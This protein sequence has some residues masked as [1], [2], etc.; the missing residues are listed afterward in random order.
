[1]HVRIHVMHRRMRCLDRHAAT[2][3]VGGLVRADPSVERVCCPL[4]RLGGQGLGQDGNCPH[5][6]WHGVYWES[7]K[8][9]F[10]CG[11]D[12]RYRQHPGCQPVKGRG[13]RFAFALR[14]KARLASHH[15][16]QGVLRSQRPPQVSPQTVTSLH[17]TL[18]TGAVCKSSDPC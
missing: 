9:P 17:L 7:V 10:W 8:I 18:Q 15:F 11:Q 14:E 4:W 16:M 1:M 6:F 2:F 12:R 13:P 5:S 3:T